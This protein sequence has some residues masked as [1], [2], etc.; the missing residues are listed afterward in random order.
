MGFSYFRQVLIS[1][2]PAVRYFSLELLSKFLGRG[3][4]LALYQ[5]AP[6][7][8]E[9]LHDFPIVNLERAPVLSDGQRGEGEKKDDR[10]LFH[11]GH[12]N[13]I[14]A[15]VGSKTCYAVRGGTI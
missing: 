8:L 9:G 1:P 12:Q 3:D 15:G 6:D 13:N 5:L 10:E 11:N 7:G 2:I 14:H 4:L